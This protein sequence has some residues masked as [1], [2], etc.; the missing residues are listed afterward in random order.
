M[1]DLFLTA[2]VFTVLPF[3]LYRPW[4]G[5]IAFYW[6]SLMNPHRLSWG[7]ATTMPFAFL[8]AGATIGGM[9]MTKDRKKVPWTAELTLMLILGLYFTVTTYFAWAQANAW[10]RWDSVMK[11][12]LMTYIMTMLIYG[13]ERIRIMLLVAALSI[14]FFGLKGGIFSLTGGGANQVR[15][16]EGSFIASNTEI[17]LA[18]L[19]VLPLL[20]F[21]ARE[22]TNKWFKR[23]LIVV[24]IFTCVSIVFTYSRGA[25][26]GMA[27]VMPLI[28]L[29][30]RAKFTFLFI[31]VPLAYLGYQWAP[32]SIFQRAESVNTYDQDRSAMQRLQAWSVSWNI[33][34]DHP[35]TG[36]GFEL[37]YH[38]DEDRWLSYANRKYD[39]FGNTSRA[40]H[41]VYFQVIGHHGL[42]AAALYFLMLIL[43]MWHLFRL[44]KVGLKHPELQWIATYADAIF[45]GMVGF[46][47]AGAFLNA[48]YFDLMYL[49]LAMAGV[50]QR[51]VTSQPSPAQPKKSWQNNIRAQSL[52]SDKSRNGS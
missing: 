46:L 40:A 48:A 30:S 6:I 42:V 26:L 16:P 28:F 45:L 49:Y 36:A 19:M 31:F 8:F 21:L 2:F 7:F 24:A 11:I 33:A 50:L 12:Y 34:L 20:I 15:G 4:V 44:R 29:K 10:H 9:M 51:E 17:G 14:G 22:E 47:V 41:S 43:L 52:A 37:E 27:V 18:M 5:V 38:P 1:R 35:L 25:M 23:L 3:S 13:R 32:E 39:D